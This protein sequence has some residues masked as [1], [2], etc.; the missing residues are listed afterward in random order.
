MTWYTLILH[1]SKISTGTVLIS[2]IKVDLQDL[3]NV[4]FFVFVLQGI[5]QAEKILPIVR[6]FRAK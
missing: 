3:V 6:R 1:E 5:S 4:K 2:Y